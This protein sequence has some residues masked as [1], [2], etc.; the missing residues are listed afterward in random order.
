[1]TSSRPYLIRAIFEWIVDNDKTPYLLVDAAYE[2]VVVPEAYI[3]NNR[4]ILNISPVAAHDIN[5]TDED[6]SF[7][8]R[9]N[10]QAMNV[11]IP[12][13]AV[14]AIYAKEN[15]QGMLFSDDDNDDPPSNADDGKPSAS[16]RPALKVVK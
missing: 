13:L 5:M 16:K 9:F 12:V 4:I 14:M 7:S 3:E 11:F 8:A 2:G 15:G 1:M 6:V 10:G